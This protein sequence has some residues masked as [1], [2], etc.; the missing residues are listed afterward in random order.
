[1]V[2]PVVILS[3]DYH[4]ATNGYLNKYGWNEFAAETRHSFHSSLPF[5]RLGIHRGGRALRELLHLTRW[6]RWVTCTVYALQATVARCCRRAMGSS[7]TKPND[8]CKDL[9]CTS[10]SFRQAMGTLT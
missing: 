7:R 10:R 9:I 5:L 2:V 4:K 3:F 6:L 8:Y 1:M